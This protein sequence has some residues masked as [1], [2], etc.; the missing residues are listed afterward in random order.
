MTSAETGGIPQTTQKR[1][2]QHRRENLMV[3]TSG[4]EENNPV[5]RYIGCVFICR[6]NV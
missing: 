3:S 5:A 1:S 6:G 4:I 2:M